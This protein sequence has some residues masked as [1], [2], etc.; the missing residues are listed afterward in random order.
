MDLS[1]KEDR[2]I[3]ERYEGWPVRQYLN[4]KAGRFYVRFSINSPLPD[5][6]GGRVTILRSHY[7]WMR[8]NNEWK[9]P[10]GYVIH[11]VDMDRQNDSPENLLLMTAAD[12]DALHRE[13]AV[14]GT[15]TGRKHSEKTIARMREIAQA[16]GNNDVWDRPDPFH[17]DSTRK[18]MSDKARGDRNPMFR[19]DL[20]AN[21]IVGH[22]RKY[23]SMQK[24]ARHFG[25]S[26]TAVRN[27]LPYDLR[28]QKCKTKGRQYP[29]EPEE[30]FSLYKEHGSAK[31]ADII[32][33][34]Q[35]NVLLNVRKARQTHEG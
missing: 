28:Y 14:E 32:G 11:H 12:H 35:G 13:M 31:T 33:C 21:E 19:A 15:F 25:C 24:T 34:S 8:A 7:V 18:L 2:H 5:K 30:Y 27:R 22:Y 6:V 17:K 9:V 3:I 29:Y 20:E 1:S 16:R 10:Y 26:I 23:R 4:R